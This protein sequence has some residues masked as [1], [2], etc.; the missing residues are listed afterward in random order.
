MPRPILRTLLSAAVGI[1]LVLGW[2]WVFSAAP[3]LA[4]NLT[5]TTCADF[6]CALGAALVSF[7]VTIAM[8]VSVSMVVGWALLWT[9]GVRPAWLVAITGP[10][11][12]WVVGWLAQ[13][14]IPSGIWRFLIPVAIGY[15]VAGLLTSRQAK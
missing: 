12:A 8:V 10:I 9:V 3:N 1:A 2:W 14:I 11:L 13:S 15:A 4:I 6:G 5:D 7:I